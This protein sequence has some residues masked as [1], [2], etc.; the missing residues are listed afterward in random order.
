MADYGSFNWPPSGGGGSGITQYANAAALPVS[1]ANGAIAETLD[2]HS[3][4]IFSTGSMTWLLVASPTNV[5]VIGTIDSTTK[6][7]NGAVITSNT[8]IMQTADATHPGLISTSTQTIA[9]NKT[10]SG[11][12]TAASVLPTVSL[13]ALGSSSLLWELFTQDIKGADGGVSITS[14]DQ[15]GTLVQAGAININPGDY[16]TNDSAG[17]AGADVTITAGGTADDG[18]STGFSG[19]V[20]ITGGAG[21][22]P[23]SVTGGNISFV[24][25][26]GSGS[27]SGGNIS[28]TAGS[29]AVP[30]T[31][32]FSSD[33][34]LLSE[35]TM[36]F[37]DS[38]N[39]FYSGLRAVSSLLASTTWMLP[40]A[41]GSP[42]QVLKTDGSGNLGWRTITVPSTGNLTEAVSSVLTITGGTNA[43]NGSGTSI[44]LNLA[45]AKIYVGNASNVPVAVS[46]SGDI[47]ITNTGATSYAGVVPLSKG[48]TNANLTA[49]NGS[50]PYS[51]ATAFSLLAP[52]TAGQLFQSGGAGAPNWTSATF[53]STASST[54]TFLRANGT[55]WVASTLT[56]PNTTTANQ[57]LYS[58][59]TS[60]VGEI[61]TAATSALVTNSSSV[62]SFT[63]GSTANRVLRTDGTTV[64]FAQVAA[65]TDISGQLPLANGGTAANLTAVQGGVVYSGASA[66]AISSAGSLGQYLMSNGTSAPSFT[67]P[68]LAAPV[69][70]KLSGSGTYNLPYT[71]VITSGS[72][73]VGAT[74]TNNAITF[75][76]F[77]TVASA[78]LVVMSGSGAP[79]TSGTL[80]KSGGTGDSTITFSRVFTPLYLQVE[81]VGEGG[82]GA[83]GGTAGGGTGGTG[84]STSFGSTTANG[85]VGAVATNNPGGA[86]GTV[87]LASGHYGNTMTGATGGGVGAF[88]IVT[89]TSYG[90]AGA[91]GVSPFGGQGYGNANGAGS[92]ASSGTGSGG[93]GGGQQNAGSSYANGG[94]GSGGYFDI[95][96]PN[97]SA[98]YSYAVGSG[99]GSG[100]GA[101][102]NGSAAGSGGSGTLI[103]KACYQ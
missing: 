13:N 73:T 76:V 74:Y 43:V 36:R 79:S 28:F 61:T 6:S 42:N 83:G 47:A 75:T 1:A 103:V 2:T 40:D 30:G 7:A 101:G 39:S 53:P 46:M 86:G 84:A 78:T 80:T 87:S 95:T 81:G 19:N 77:A 65:A 3:L 69:V 14:L 38:G 64:S 62:P 60:V 41:D 49:S 24:G 54:G 5:N 72:A 20:V 67:S 23:G 22:G 90:A 100:G 48:G 71:F 63:S 56:L 70:Q 57:I 37:Y 55:N 85:G 89:T 50:I 68:I 44:E 93:G 102:T 26:A 94:G 58:S 45:N 34:S 4:Y 59:S 32:Q 82:G 35:H 97:P 96:I 8:L 18:G 66:L 31:I 88:E 25:G 15:S 29:G 27:G 16:L 9:G 21:I 99:S 33:L 52:G 10:F 91:G 11:T 92:N 51:T 12:I 98:T 17:V